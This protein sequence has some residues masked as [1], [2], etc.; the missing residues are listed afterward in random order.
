MEKLNLDKKTLRNFGVTMGAAFFIIG[1][2]LIVKHKQIPHPVLLIS[3]AWFICAFIIPEFL[4]PLYIS[5][6]K[7][8]FILS[9]INTRII[10]FIMFYLIFTPI[11]AAIRIFGTDLLKRKIDKNKSSYWASPDK[12]AFNKLSYE[13]Q[14]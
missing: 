2:I 7:F 10:L 8:A 6:M 3:A 1:I 13:K 4:K 11:G 14:F 5:W 9:W 12:K